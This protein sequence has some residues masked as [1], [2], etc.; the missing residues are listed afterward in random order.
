MLQNI[1]AL[2]LFFSLGFLLKNRFGENGIKA[3]IDFVI[4]VALPA[5]V[6]YNIYY[7]N[8]SFD[9]LGII[10]L[11]W[12]AVLASIGLSYIFGRILKLDKKT[13]IVFIIMA[14]F[15]NTAFMGYPFTEALLGKEGLGYTIL[16]DNFAS[17]VPVMTLGILLLSFASSKK[18]RGMDFTKILTF[19]PFIAIFT[20][21][22]LKFFNIPDFLLS[23]LDVLGSSVTPL[24]LFAV[25]ASI[26]IKGIFKKS[27]LI[28]A[29]LAVKM[30]IIPIFALL[31]LYIL[32]ITLSTAYK[33]AIIELSMPPMVLA[34]ILVID[35]GLDKDLAVGSV[36]LGIII[37]FVTVPAIFYLSGILF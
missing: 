5:A 25:G 30:V 27:S 4:Y 34:S 31:I 6:V 36:A 10:I 12:T 22:F 18:R 1:A 24:A 29:I 8:F 26:D 28:T 2:L 3:L 20:A 19:P 33:A 9:L 21:I 16:F 17:F 13:L 35:E 14:T 11:G 23:A 37:S 15:G 7:L 32:Q